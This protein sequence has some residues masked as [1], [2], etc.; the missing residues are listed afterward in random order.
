MYIWIKINT[1]GVSID[2][3]VNWEELCCFFPLPVVSLKSAVVCSTP[4]PLFSQIS[5][6]CL[7]CV[8][9]EIQ[10]VFLKSLKIS[11]FHG[12]WSPSI[13]RWE[14]QQY[15]IWHE[16]KEL[17]VESKECHGRIFTP[18][19]PPPHLWGMPYSELYG[20]GPPK[21]AGFF[22]ACSIRVRK[23]FIFVF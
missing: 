13:V 18:L 6:T 15:W 20:E 10:E 7:R 12:R 1:K 11:L 17:C 3:I 19:P 4:F 2:N 22:Y 16:G 23:I 14:S 8:L 21:R 5:D 9:I